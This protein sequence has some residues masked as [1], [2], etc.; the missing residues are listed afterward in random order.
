TMLPAQI[1]GL[2][3]AAARKRA[4]KLLDLV[5]LGEAK[6]KIPNEL[7]GGMQQRASIAR[8]LL[9]DPPILFMDEPFG[10]LDAI[11]RKEMGDE[12]QRI[13]QL[14]R[15]TV[16]FVTHSIQEA[17]MLADRVLVFSS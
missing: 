16:L 5:G 15:K 9:H 3:K 1:L 13:H 10:A 12:L 7:S 17:V 11:T 8:S 2:G 4:S 14:Q 6:E